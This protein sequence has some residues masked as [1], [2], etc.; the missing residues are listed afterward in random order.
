MKYTVDILT[1]RL[2]IKDACNQLFTDKEIQ[3]RVFRVIC[4]KVEDDIIDYGEKEEKIIRCRDCRFNKGKNKCLNEH[5]IIHI[6]KDDDFCSYG[7]AKDD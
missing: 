5:S 2:S 6:P 3:D 1:L 4:S 7:K